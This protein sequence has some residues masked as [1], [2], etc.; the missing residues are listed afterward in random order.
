MLDFYTETKSYLKNSTF[1]HSFLNN[2]FF[3]T[4]NSNKNITNTAWG[5]S[6][7]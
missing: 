1:I 4:R 6:I 7:L 3:E 5:L 2:I